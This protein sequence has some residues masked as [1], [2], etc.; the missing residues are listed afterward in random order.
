M[1]FNAKCTY[2]G[3]EVK[4]SKKGNVYKI[5]KLLDDNGKTFSVLTTVDVP[6][7]VKYLDLINVELELIFAYKN[8][9][10]RAI[11]IWKE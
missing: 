2:T 9:Y 8:I 7:G 11:K 3:M 1:K 10:I 6:E 4:Q 5:I